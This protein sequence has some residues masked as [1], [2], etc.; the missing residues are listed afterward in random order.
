M[1]FLSGWTRRKSKIVN[2]TTAGAQT[3]Y[4]LKLTVYK[5]NGVDTSTDIY[6]GTNVRD[7]FGDVRFTK[8]D[9]TTLLDYWIETYT[10]GVSAE[11]WIEIDSI[12]IS[13]GSAVIY[14]YYDSPS[15][16]TTSNGINTFIVFN[17]GFLTGWNSVGASIVGGKISVAAALLG[18]NFIGSPTPISRPAVIEFK[19][20]GAGFNNNWGFHVQA[21]APVA[22]TNLN[23]VT[24]H[25]SGNGNKYTVLADGTTQSPSLIAANDTNEHLFKIIWATTI[26]ETKFYQDGVQKTTP[27]GNFPAVTTL[28]AM[29]GGDSTPPGDSKAFT[30]DDIRVRLYATPEPAF[31][32]TGNETTQTQPLGNLYKTV[33][34]GISFAEGTGISL[35]RRKTKLR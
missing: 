1:G 3:N 4:Q 14:I 16:T 31:G 13:P 7:D 18:A 34:R 5:S 8:S 26:G 9:G 35:G 22:Y 15:Q 2:G 29:F 32:A 11:I 33:Q 6:L 20:A 24:I 19:A 25:L 10:S 27:A 12:P 21:A 17:D 23:H 30:L 28:Y